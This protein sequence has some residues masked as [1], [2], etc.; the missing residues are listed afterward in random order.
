MLNTTLLFPI[1]ALLS[2]IATHL[3]KTYIA[4]SFWQT[5]TGKPS[6]RLVP[7]AVGALIFIVLGRVGIVDVGGIDMEALWGL[8][9]GG[10]AILAFHAKRYGKGE[11]K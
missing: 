8:G 5:S 9:M 1:V 11:R 2:Y 10:S 4:P 3:V 7:V 6:L